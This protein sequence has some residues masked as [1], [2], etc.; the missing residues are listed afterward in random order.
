MAGR[1]SRAHSR[2]C[3][4]SLLPDSALHS[5]LMSA[6]D[7]TRFL[8]ALALAESAIGLT[9]PN[10]RVG[11]VIGNEHGEVFGVGAT[12]QA[13]G[14]HAEVMALRAA[15]SAGHT[16]RGATAWVT[17]EPC[18]HHGRTPP[19]C[20]ALIEQGLAR[21]VVA[22]QDPFPGVCGQGIAR[23]RAAGIQVEGAA[24]DLAAAAWGLNIG[25]FSRVL[26]QRP[27]VRLKVAATLDG[28]TSLDNGVSQWITGEAARAD[29]HAWRHR[30]SAVL[31]GIGTVLS[32]DPRLDVR[33]V[34]SRWQP[35]R[36]VVDAQLR[37]PV[38]ARLLVA[39]GRTIVACADADPKRAVALQAAGAEVLCMPQ[40]SSSAEARSVDLV[41]LLAA[42]AARGI[43]ELHVEAGPRL[44]TSLLAAG[45]VDELLV[46]LAPTVVG[47]GQGMVTWP[48]LEQLPTEHVWAF[49][50][51]LA[52]GVDYRLRLVRQP[53]RFDHG[54]AAVPMSADFTSPPT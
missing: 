18:A 4:T 22:L 39:P 41:A 14:P 49:H 17:L 38:N 32:D 12:Q 11:C 50:S 29:G 9:E 3:R 7:R 15:A 24:P 13:G 54:L 36:V 46:Y 34:P 44:N 16:V 53:A 33:L 21:V 42:L 48:A 28:R 5:V 47:P 6:L 2:H 35:T 52:V 45:L 8:E 26:R 30:A 31:T 27:W 23:L 37:L 10:P 43:N 40:R 1:F 51:G 19:C 25:F 20:D